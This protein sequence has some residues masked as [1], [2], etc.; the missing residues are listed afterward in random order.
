MN[1]LKPL[2]IDHRHLRELWRPTSYAIGGVW[3]R[4]EMW[5]CHG[6][7]TLCFVRPMLGSD[8]MPSWVEPASVDWRGSTAVVLRTMT[9]YSALPGQKW[10]RHEIAGS[11]WSGVSECSVVRMAPPLPD[12]SELVVS[13]VNQQLRAMSLGDPPSP[14]G[15]CAFPLAT[16]NEQ[17]EACGTEH[18]VVFR[19]GEDGGA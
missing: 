1:R 5:I 15:W 16:L 12:K 4:C 9:A 8:V 13:V 7:E 19:E 3:F 14:N 11:V 10:D 17:A 2:Q 6:P 18:I